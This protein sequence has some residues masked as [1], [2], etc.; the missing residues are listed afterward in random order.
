VPVSESEAVTAM[1]RELG[2]QLAARRRAAGYAQREFGVLAGYSRSVVANAEAGGSGVGRQLWERA[3]RVLATGELFSRGYDRIQVQKAAEFRSAGR[4][5][6]FTAEPEWTSGLGQL[7]DGVKSPSLSEA[8][9]AYALRGWPVEEG[10]GQ[11]VWL[12]TGMVID[13]LEVPRAAGMVAMNW[14]LYT[15]GLP[16]DIRGLPALPDPTAA[17]AAITA[18][19]ACYFLTRS[20]ASPW[21]SRDRDPAD[22]AEPVSPVAVRWHADG[23]R[24]PSPPSELADGE[25]A[26]WAHVPPAGSQLASPMALL[27]LLAQAVAT[28]QHGAALLLPGGVRALPAPAV[29]G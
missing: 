11:R 20:G 4:S 7:P 28:T 16:D 3:D 13:A 22:R 10:I 21:T 2:R 26:T 12:L 14:W 29:P 25:H 15:H 5:Q 18:G 8:R 17:L 23:G 6:A 24:V 27:H 19:P 9:Q 1:R